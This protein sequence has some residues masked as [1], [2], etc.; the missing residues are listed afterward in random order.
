MDTD[1]PSARRETTHFV[2]WCVVGAALATGVAGLLTIGV[3]VLPL[4]VVA[5]AATLWLVG[6]DRG[7][8]GLVSGLSAAPLLVAWGSRGG[9]GEVCRAQAADATYVSC[10]E[11]W[12]PWPWLAAGVVL[13]V[14][15]V[16]VFAA[17]GRGRVTRGVGAVAAS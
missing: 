5:G 1:R 12:N 13:V 3:V 6:L 4:A 8:A 7:L 11:A 2:A 17:V 15:G 10:I 14:V 9:P 16:A